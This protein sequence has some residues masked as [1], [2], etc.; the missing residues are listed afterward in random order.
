MGSK[1]KFNIFL[2]LLTNENIIFMSKLC[3][4]SIL[5]FRDYMWGNFWQSLLKSPITA[6]HHVCLDMFEGEGLKI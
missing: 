2:R 1:V 3:P 4:H 6:Q 5:T